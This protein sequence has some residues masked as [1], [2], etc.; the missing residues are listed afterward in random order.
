MGLIGKLTIV[1]LILAALLALAGCLLFSFV[2]DNRAKWSMRDTLHARSR[3]P[4]EPDAAAIWFREYRQPVRRRSRDGL[5]LSGWLFPGTASHRYAI[6]CHGYFDTP[7]VT[8]RYARHFQELGYTVLCPAAR[9]HE[10]S[11]GRFIGM[12]WPDRLDVADWAQW[13]TDRDPAAEL[14][15]FGISMGGATV[16]MAAGEPLPPGVR[17][18]ISDCGYSSVWAEFASQIRRRSPLPLYPVLW[19]MD[20]VTRLRAGWGFREA[21][22]VKQLHKAVLPMLFIHG[23]ADKF[24]PYAMLDQV[25]T[26]CASPVK[27]KLTVHGA[28]HCQSVQVDP[29]TYWRTVDR[30]L[31][32]AFRSTG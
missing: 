5:L 4:R 6:V 27:E 20:A 17:C 12:G 32:Q 22:A 23:D 25:Y 11:E 1:L 15:L 24:V 18:I 10:R 31:T 2:L 13:L 9:A 30:F 26:A 21:S 16:M 29:E 14:F 19:A 28:A 7:A 3:Q 8:A